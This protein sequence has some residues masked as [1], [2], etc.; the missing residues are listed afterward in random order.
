MS[1]NARS[2]GR[3]A[4]PPAT[5]EGGKTSGSNGGARGS[6]GAEREGGKGGGKAS[7]ARKGSPILDWIRSI[8]SALVLFL[9]IRAFLIQT[10]VITSGSMEDTLL[11]GD[12]LVVNRAALGSRI[13]GTSLRIPGYSHVERGQIIVFD[14]PHEDDLKLVKRLIGLPGDTL[15]MRDKVLYVNGEPREEPYV[16]HVD[17]GDETHPWMEW[18]ASYLPADVSP[19]TYRPTRDNWGPIVVPGD[20]YFML[21]DNRDTSLDS[22]YW[23]FLE[24]WRLEGRAVFIYYSY[25]SSSL[26]PFPWLRDVRW[27]RVGTLIR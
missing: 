13:P 15:A 1:R 23:G 5:L 21:G 7:R 20:H 27:G 14:P 17:P 2:R 22:R 18:Q 9:I 8:V 10:F 26:H 16:R 4:G 25:E 19:E 11:V 12:M 3:G 24:R 6:R